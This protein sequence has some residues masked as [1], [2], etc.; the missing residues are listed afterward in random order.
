MRFYI[1]LTHDGHGDRYR[2]S[3]PNDVGE[4]DTLLEA[5]DSLERNIKGREAALNSKAKQARDALAHIA[6]AR[7]VAKENEYK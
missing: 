2:S 6:E 3:T 4:G 1:T 7:E 5:I